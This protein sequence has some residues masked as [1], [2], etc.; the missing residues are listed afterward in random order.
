MRN[1][2]ILVVDGDPQSRK[3]VTAALTEADFEV[4]SA[5]DGSTGIELARRVQPAVIILDIMTSVTDGMDTL[6]GFKRDP[7]LKDVPVIAITASSDLTCADKAFRAGAQFFLPKPFRGASLLGLVELAADRS[8]K[9]TPMQRRRRHP[10]HPAEIPVS[11]VVEDHTHTNR[12]LMGHTA[13][14]S[15]SGL[16]MALPEGLEKGTTL[17]VKLELPE[18]PITAKGRVMWQDPKQAEDGRFHHGVRLLGFT[19]EGALTQYRR[20]LSRLAE[21]A[22]G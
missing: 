20:Q 13:N 15:L 12:E 14:V 11:C 4:V 22:T 7:G 2:P 10:R 17:L 9:S 19:E 3:L 8:Q 5:L 18:G 6:Q 1:R 16:S 21:E